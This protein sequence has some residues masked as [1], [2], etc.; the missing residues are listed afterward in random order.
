MLLGEDRADEADDGA[1]VGEDADDVG[2]AADLPVEPL[3]GVVRSD[4]PPDLLR[5]GGEGEHVG[6]GGVE[7][8]GHRRELVGQGVEDAVELACTAAASGWS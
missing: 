6:A 8:S 4:L 1:A 3:G 5:K 2:A 7:V